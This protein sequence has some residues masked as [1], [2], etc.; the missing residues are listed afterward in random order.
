MR[1]ALLNKAVKF[2]TVTEKNSEKC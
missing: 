1:K 2:Q